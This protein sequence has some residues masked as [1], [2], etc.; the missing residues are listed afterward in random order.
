MTHRISGGPSAATRGSVDRVLLVT[1]GDVSKKP[2]AKTK[3]LLHVNL[4]RPLAWLCRDYYDDPA[5]LIYPVVCR[6]K[7][8]AFAV[9]KAQGYSLPPIPVYE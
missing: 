8:D 7:R 4:R 9:T 3:K 1:G 5:D 2:V 6:S